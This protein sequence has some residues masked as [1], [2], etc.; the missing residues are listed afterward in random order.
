MH[1][2]KPS[3]KLGMEINSYKLQQQLF[4]F[5]FSFGRA[6]SVWGKLRDTGMNLQSKVFCVF[7]KTSY[8]PYTAWIQQKSGM[9]CWFS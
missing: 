4:G 5:V 2:S 6:V 9:F 3:G 7:M 1:L 8:L